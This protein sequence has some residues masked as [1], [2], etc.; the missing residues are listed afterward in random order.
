MNNIIEI[1]DLS[2]AYGSKRVLHH[3]NLNVAAGT[4]Y[5]L[6]GRNGAGKTT[7]LKILAGL[8]VPRGGSSSVIG[9]DSRDLGPNEWMQIGYVSESQP[10]YD[11]LTGEELI[12]FT[13][14]LYP[15]WDQAFCDLL[16]KRMQL[17]IDR[18]VRSY[19]KG[20]R[21]KMSLLLAMAFHPKLLLL[22]EPFSGLDVLAKE[23][24]ISCL[25]EATQQA[26][27]SVALASHDLAEVERLADTIGLIEE[28]SLK[29]SEPLE[30]LQGRYRKVQV[31]GARADGT[32]DASMTQV[33]KS[34]NGF[35]FVETAFS[36]GRE[37]SLRQRYG[38]QVEITPM[39]LREIMLALLS[40][41][42]LPV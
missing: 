18:K 33:A 31:F 39:A 14:A 7:L 13:S 36:P 30:T 15:N 28:G 17:P 29:V 5:A 12:A 27:W 21:M 35:S 20:E 19:S 38:A 22:D 34:E 25:L 37:Q 9:C 8:L 2:H 6:L 32:T 11:W 4:F 40:T 1:N 16:L 26:H 24:L 10:M 23:Q 41:E 42:P 3:I